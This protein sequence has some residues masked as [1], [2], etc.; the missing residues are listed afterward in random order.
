MKKT[1]MTRWSMTRADV[2]RAVREHFGIP[3]S[4]EVTLNADGSAE[5]IQA[6]L[7]DYYEFLLNSYS[8][9][10]D[11]LNPLDRKFRKGDYIKYSSYR[12]KI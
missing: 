12:D 5:A 9:L 10:D 8:S 7:P 11:L 6:P 4:A 3:D 2:E 1:T